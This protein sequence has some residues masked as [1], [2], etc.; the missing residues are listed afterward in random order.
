MK[1]E[2][3]GQQGT[4]SIRY[5]FDDR[6]AANF[7]LVGGRGQAVAASYRSRWENARLV[8]RIDIPDRQFRET[9]SL[10]GAGEM[11]VETRISGRGGR[12]A[13]YRKSGP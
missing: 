1:I 13:I 4:S 2:S 5:T 6:P 8:T 10:N 11:L 7:M 9:I 12:T 3:R